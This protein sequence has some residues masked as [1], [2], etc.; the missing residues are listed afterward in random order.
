MDLTYILHLP[1]FSYSTNGPNILKAVPIIHWVLL[2]LSSSLLVASLY[3]N[4]KSKWSLIIIGLMYGALFYITNLYFVVPY[5]QTDASVSRFIEF[6]LSSK[7]ITREA[8]SVYSLSYLSY[9]VSFILEISMM[10]IGGMGKISIYTVGLFVFLGAF[11]VGLILYYYKKDRDTKFAVLSLAT[12]IVLSFYVINDQVA[13]QTLALA[14]LPYLYRL[15]FDYIEGEQPLKILALILIL[16]FALVFTHPFMFLFYVLPVLG[17]VVYNRVILKRSG[18]KD[19][20]IWIMVSTWGFGFVYLFYNLLSAPIKAFV[21]SWGKA[22]GET[23]WMFAN[24]FRKSGA[25][26]P[27]KYIPHPHYELVPKWI[28]ETQALILRIMLILFVGIISYSFI[29]QLK[30][31]IT[32]GRL[33]HQLVFDVSVILSSGVVFIIGLITTFLGQRSFQVAFIPF[34]RYVLSSRTKK[35]VQ[36]TLIAILIIAPVA[37]TFNVLINLTVGSQIFVYDEKSLIAGYFGNSYLPPFSKVLVAR[38]PYPSEYPI[39]IIKYSIYG[40]RSPL[41][42]GTLGYNYIYMSPKLEYSAQYYGIS[43]YSSRAYLLYFYSAVYT[44]NESMVMYCDRHQN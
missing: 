41:Y 40:Y 9:P 23:W 39:N 22:Q 7:R 3:L 34:S 19:S 31:A 1:K 10:L 25:L 42:S 30:R 5:E 13:P 33:S 14:F 6:M 18:I 12:Y 20:T 35:V 36:Y 24:F 37:Y 38:E 8:L 16:W 15:T 2:I 26:G 44:N 29:H 17:V 43:H 32:S 11:Y 28:V 21:E 4:R 27:I